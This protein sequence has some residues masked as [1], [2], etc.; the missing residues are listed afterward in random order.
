MLKEN[1]GKS[2]SRSKTISRR[3]FE[4]NNHYLDWV[5]ACKDPDLRNKIASHFGEAGPFNEM[6]LMGMLAVRL[7]KLNRILDWDGEN[8]QFTNISDTDRVSIFSQTFDMGRMMAQASSQARTAGGAAPA[9]GGAPAGGP[10]G[11]R[12]ADPSV[13]SAKEFVTS[14]IR[15]EYLNGYK[16]PDMP[17]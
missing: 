16:L 4:D 12:P 15:H 9:R 5:A 3:S 2:N 8:M 7:Q 13:V 10:G 6:V 11:Q 14:L 17:V 1:S